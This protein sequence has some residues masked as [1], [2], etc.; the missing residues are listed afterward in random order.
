MLSFFG[1]A[2]CVVLFLITDGFTE[3]LDGVITQGEGFIGSSLFSS[4][5]RFSNDFVLMSWGFLLGCIRRLLFLRCLFFL[6]VG[7]SHFLLCFYLFLFVFGFFRL[8]L[9]V[10]R[11]PSS[12]RLVMHQLA[13][14]FREVV[15]DHLEFVVRFFRLA[16]RLFRLVLFCF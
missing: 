3:S 16:V 11:H 4:M 14:R 10:D 15:V 5:I 1:L 7:Y 13:N 6:F 9:F 2:G 8:C 12:L